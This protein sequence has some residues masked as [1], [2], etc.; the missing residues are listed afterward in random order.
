PPALPAPASPPCPT[1]PPALSRPPAFLLPPLIHHFAPPVRI[2]IAGEAFTASVEDGERNEIAR[3]ARRAALSAVWRGRVW[4]IGRF[5]GP[6]RHVGA[7]R[8]LRGVRRRPGAPSAGHGAV[9]TYAGRQPEA[10]RGARLAWR[11]RVVP[12]RR[13]LRPRRHE[14]RLGDVEPRPQG[15]E[16]C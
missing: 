5:E 1:S 2:P 8:L 15:N 14:E 7:S 10:R 12:G 11:W 6:L 16:R 13:G 3:R 9:R 4:S